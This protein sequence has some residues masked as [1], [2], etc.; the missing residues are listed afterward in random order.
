M[1]GYGCEFGARGRAEW[2]REFC[3]EGAS[4][5]IRGFVL[6]VVL[7][8]LVGWC[9]VQESFKQTQARYRLAELSRYEDEA[10]KQLAK[11][12]A[13]EEELR[14]PAHLARLVREKR[15]DVV[16]LGRAMPEQ[17][18]VATAA[19]RPG[20]VLDDEI[21]GFGGDGVNVASSGQW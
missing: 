16:A 18:P 13:K 5:S 19:R 1:I 4:L 7:L 2:M 9:M 21:A 17:A 14:S 20:E 6:G 3:R 8:A 12:R 10:K 11:L 15:L